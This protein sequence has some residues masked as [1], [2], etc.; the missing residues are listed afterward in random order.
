VRHH[1]RA[2][3]R[4]RDSDRIKGGNSRH[5]RVSEGVSGFVRPARV[6]PRGIIPTRRQPQWSSAFS[7]DRSNQTSI[8]Q[9]T[10]KTAPAKPRIFGVRLIRGSG[11]QQRD[12]RGM[13]PSENKPARKRLLT[14]ES[15]PGVGA[16]MGGF[17]QAGAGIPGLATRRA[18]GAFVQISR[19]CCGIC[20]SAPSPVG[21][22]IAPTATPWGL[23]A[24]GG[25]C[26][27]DYPGRP[28]TGP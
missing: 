11:G 2:R 15:L 23:A 10:L 20:G 8:D 5:L 27:T 26:H 13:G 22:M 1:L 17:R 4:C 12:C 6:V 3:T 21:A 18:I 25:C 14:L 28:G 16:L 19:Y 24:T 9:R 7:S